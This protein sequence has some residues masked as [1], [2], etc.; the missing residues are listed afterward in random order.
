[1]TYRAAPRLALAMLTALGALSASGPETRAATP[2][3]PA[4]KAPGKVESILPAG[5]RWTPLPEASD[6]FT[7]KGL[8]DRKWKKGLWYA[9]SGELAF[10][11]S[12]V[13][14]RNDCLVLSARN[15]KAKGKNFTI[16]AVESKFDVPTNSYVEIRA[17]ALDKSANV[18]SAIWMQSSWD[19]KATNPGPEIDIQETFQYD[20]LC[21]ALHTWG[22]AGHIAH[23][24]Y[25]HPV[26]TDVSRDFHLYG[27]ERRDGKLRFY[28][29]GKLCYETAPKDLS[30][31]TMPR[32]VVLSLEGHLG[33]PVPSELPKEFLI[34][35]VR[36]FRYAGSAK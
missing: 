26:G 16:G 8:D 33:R 11:D 19:S 1:M 12:N 25:N 13:E 36:T 10:K 28:F 35:H 21:T 5:S 3:A 24:G 6:E 18:L 29:D 34:D 31:V 7:Q 14:V 32:H 30:L 22:P 17:K 15:E 2:S 23:G 27:L 20:Q 4:Q 9:V